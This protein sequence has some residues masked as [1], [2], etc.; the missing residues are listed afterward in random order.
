MLEWKE[1]G[2]LGRRETGDGRRVGRGGSA[3]SI[4]FHNKL[5]FEGNV[6]VD[7]LHRKNMT[8]SKRCSPKGVARHCAF[9]TWGMGHVACGTV[10][11]I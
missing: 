5:M 8:R 4:L 6:S 11:S 3:S 2:E 1:K 7:K 10:F 9:G